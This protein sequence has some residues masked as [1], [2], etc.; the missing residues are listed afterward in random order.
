MQ[1][2]AS[3]CVIRA[4]TISAGLLVIGVSQAVACEDSAIAGAWRGAFFDST[5]TFEFARS[6][7][8][9]SGQSQPSPDLD[10]RKPLANLTVHDCTISFDPTKVT[11]P[12]HV[13]LKIDDAGETLSG[14]VTFDGIPMI[15]PLTLKRLK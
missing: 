8:G 9:W 13:T 11:P 3:T 5:L 4:L 12:Q 2:S 10:F 15:F 6:D 7:T 14:K 1:K